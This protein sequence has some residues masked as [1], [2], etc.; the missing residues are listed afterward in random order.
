V[1][2]TNVSIGEGSRERRLPVTLATLGRAFERRGII[3][4][5]PAKLP[6][7]ALTRSERLRDT[8]LVRY[9]V[10]DRTGALVR[11]LGAA[12]MAPWDAFTRS[13]LRTIVSRPR[14]TWRWGA[15]K[16]EIPR[17]GRVV[18]ESGSVGARDRDAR[19]PR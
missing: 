4:R 16:E 8:A 2:A 18:R 7:P 19:G 13:A 3:D 6:V 10:G 1:H 5:K 9:F 17:R 11:I 12:L 14:P 15:A